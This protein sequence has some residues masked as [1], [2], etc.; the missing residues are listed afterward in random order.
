MRR[1]RELER[2]SAARESSQDSL[3]GAREA[4]AAAEDAAHRERGRQGGGRRRSRGPGT[5]LPAENGGGAAL[6]C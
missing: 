2:R 6:P 4:G 3:R 1:E 5:E